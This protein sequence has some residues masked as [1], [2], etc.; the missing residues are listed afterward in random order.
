MSRDEQVTCHGMKDVFNMVRSCFAE[1]Y[2]QFITISGLNQSR[3]VEFTCSTMD[4]VLSR[5]A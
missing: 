1:S 5:P 3:D 4:V 2:I